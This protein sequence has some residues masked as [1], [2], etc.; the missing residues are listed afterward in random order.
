MVNNVV[1]STRNIDDFISD[2]ANE[3]VRKINQTENKINDC[4]QPTNDW[5]NLNELCEYLPD[6]PAKATVYSWVHNSI[7]PYHKGGKKLRFLKAEINE[8]LKTGR[9]KTNAEIEKDAESYL[10]EKGSK[11][12]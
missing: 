2:L 12:S 5:L 3:V 6:K 9:R 10:K 8:W 11:A 4:S 7:I 1:L